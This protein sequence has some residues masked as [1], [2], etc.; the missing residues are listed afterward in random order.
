MSNLVYLLRES[1]KACRAIDSSA[2]LAQAAD[3]IER[4]E[5]VVDAWEAAAESAGMILR[6]TDSGPNL[7]RLNSFT[8]TDD[9]I[10][11][12]ERA[13]DSLVGVEDCSS[14]ASELDDGAACTLRSL[15]DRIGAK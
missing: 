11:A 6:N 3:A 5:G 2:L 15:L 7:V 9:E 1:I 12:V 10:T 8:L 14:D 4:L 13:I